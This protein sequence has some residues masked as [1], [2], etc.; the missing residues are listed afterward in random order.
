VVYDA[1]T[2][3]PL[4]VLDERLVRQGQGEQLTP[5]TLTIR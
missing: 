5:D 2:L 4:H 3:E 1:F